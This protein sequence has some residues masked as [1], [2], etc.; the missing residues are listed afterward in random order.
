MPKSRYAS[1]SL[2]I[3]DIWFNRAEYNDIYAPH[4]QAI[5]DRLLAHGTTYA[6]QHMTHH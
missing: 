3:S 5:Y 1:V 6:F 2:Y 4:D